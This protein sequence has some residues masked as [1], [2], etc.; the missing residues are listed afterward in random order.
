MTRNARR[1]NNE[2][3]A[4]DLAAR[5]RSA[6]TTEAMNDA[7]ADLTDP[8]SELPKAIQMAEGIDRALVAALDNGWERA[9]KLERAAA[10]EAEG[11][12]RRHEGAG[13]EIR[14]V[15]ADLTDK[16]INGDEAVRRCGL[17]DEKYGFGTVE[18]YREE[19]RLE[20]VG[21]E[22]DLAGKR[23]ERDVLDAFIAAT[24]TVA[25]GKPLFPFAP[26]GTYADALEARM[27]IRRFTESPMFDVWAR[28]VIHGAAPDGLADS[29]AQQSMDAIRAAVAPT[30]PA[31]YLA[32]DL[33]G[34][35]S[36]SAETVPEPDNVQDLGMPK[37]GLIV[38]GALRQKRWAATSWS[39]YLDGHTLT[40]TV[41]ITSWIAVPDSA[42]GPLLPFTIVPVGGPKPW[43][44]QPATDGDPDVPWSTPGN[45]DAAEGRFFTALAGWLE[46]KVAVTES[47]AAPRYIRRRWE[48]EG[49]D[50][51]TVTHVKLRALERRTWDPEAAENRGREFSH[52]WVVSGHWRDQVCGP[53]RSR[54]R[55]VYIAPYIK[56]PADKPLVVKDRIWKVDR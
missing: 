39:T 14:Q 41:L 29:W 30:A 11:E 27:A 25:D 36:E 13:K 17:I 40:P 37:A 9:A 2:T 22:H 48:R 4:R 24:Q 12:A 43:L 50:V 51:P 42:V 34:P 35:M 46:S 10:E 21:L 32:A 44:F 6:D 18:S 53:A 19:L 28:R 1:K 16:Q 52:Q 47:R 56:G 3:K 31:L 26:T 8:E 20:Q 23:T 5:L 54:R 45:M 15:I 55:P 49:R 38:Y 7:L 33:V